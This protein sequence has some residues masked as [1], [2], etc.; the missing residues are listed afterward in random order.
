M[1]GGSAGFQIGGQRAQM[2][3]FFIGVSDLEDT[4]EVTPVLQMKASAAAGES[5]IGISGG[6]NPAVE[7]EVITVSHAEGLYAGATFEG[8]V[9]GPD[10]GANE[11]LYGRAVTV[12]ELLVDRTV[13]VPDVARGLIDAVIAETARDRVDSGGYAPPDVRP[14]ENGWSL[15]ENAPTWRADTV[16]GLRPGNTS[17]EATVVHYLASR[18]RGDRAFAEVLPLGITGD[19]RMQ[20][21]LAE[22]DQWTFRAFRLVGR[23]EAESGELWIKVW[24]QISCE[25]DEDSGE[26]EFTVLCNEGTCLVTSVPT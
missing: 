7:S 13:D 8:L 23:K 10:H 2:V 5:G 15:Y 20:R 22:H 17:A 14:G 9:V 1:G 21:K 4:T 3:M 11:A 16:A 12:Q 6:V 24:M 18:V 26:D 19:E 25:G